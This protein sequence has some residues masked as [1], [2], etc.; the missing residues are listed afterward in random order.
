MKKFFEYT[1]LRT[2]ITSVFTF[3]MALGLLL[4]Q[5]VSLRVLPTAVFFVSMLTFDLATTAINN[6]IDTKTNG[7]SLP[8]PRDLA[9]KIIFILLGLAT[10]LGLVLV[11][12]TDLIVLLVGALCFACGVIYTYGPVAIS[13]IPL[14]EFLSGVFY[15]VFIPFLMFYINYPKG[16]II[17]YQ[18]GGGRLSLD[19]SLWMMLTIAIVAITPT[20]TTANIMLANN[21]SDLKKDVENSRFTLPHYIGVKSA[22]SL[23]RGLYLLAYGGIVLMAVFRVAPWTA[24]LA[25]LTLPLAMSNVKVFAQEQVKS[26]TFVTAIKNFVLIN[27]S[28]V[29]G[30]FLGVVLQKM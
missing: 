10:A 9:K 3:F 30:T 29:F 2:K 28:L 6:Y 27:G 24:L 13:R 15:G 14:G 20:A 5:G 18:P 22:I 8:Y 25:L 26:K 12:M 23:Y 21:T 1:E 4:F 19:I 16:T 7:E 17:A 11:A